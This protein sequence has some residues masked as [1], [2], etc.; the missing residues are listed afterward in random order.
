M[1]RSLNAQH[2]QIV[3]TTTK[4]LATTC[5]RASLED[6]TTEGTVRIRLADGSVHCAVLATE[7]SDQALLGAIEARKPVVVCLMEEEWVILGLLRDRL[8]L[9]PAGAIGP[10]VELEA[11]DSLIIG[12]GE[13]SIELHASGRIALRGHDVLVSSSGTT[14]I[15][16]ATV[17]VN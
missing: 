14:A 5:Q 16:G 11:S 6:V 17:R 2:L 8:G 3:E 4:S 15:Q 13:A 9:A 12:C 1:R 7:E 10:R